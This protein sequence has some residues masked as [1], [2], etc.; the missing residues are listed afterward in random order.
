MSLACMGHSNS[1]HLLE[2]SSNVSTERLLDP[3]YAELPTCGDA[4]FSHAN[5]DSAP[6][7]RASVGGLPA[8]TFPP[9]PPP[10][11]LLGGRVP[12]VLH[13]HSFTQDSVRVD[14]FI[15]FH[16]YRCQHFHFFQQFAVYLCSKLFVQMIL[17]LP[18]G[19]CLRLGGARPALGGH[20]LPL[21][22]KQMP[23]V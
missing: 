21:W 10:C 14:L 23:Q 16:G 6:G 9:A 3:L 22:C 7:A 1:D 8:P 5:S 13:D 12:H 11:V 20:S 17:G 15:C 4:L 2:V 18:S 19:W